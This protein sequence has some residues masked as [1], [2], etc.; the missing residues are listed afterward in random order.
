MF[1]L[2]WKHVHPVLTCMHL[3]VKIQ[4]MHTLQVKMMRSTWVNVLFTSHFQL[5]MCITWEF[6]S[7]HK[8]NQM[9]TWHRLYTHSNN[10]WT[11]LL[12]T[13]V[14]ETNCGMDRKHTEHIFETYPS[15]IIS[16]KLCFCGI[17]TFVI[18]EW[19]TH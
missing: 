7:T 13:P 14:H 5:C 9:H 10:L 15:D 6:L 16:R 1:I 4:C 2:Q 17:S 3:L 8:E 11:M 12:D 18:S 19:H